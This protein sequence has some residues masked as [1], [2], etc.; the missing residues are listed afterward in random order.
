M[1][2]RMGNED[3]V[4]LMLALIVMIAA[5][6]AVSAIASRTMNQSNH[7]MAYI[8]FDQTLQGI[9]A[10]FALARVELTGQAG[11]NPE[12][13]DGRIGVDTSYDLTASKPWFGS[14]GVTPFHMESMPDVEYFAFSYDWSSDGVDNNGDGTIDEAAEDDYYSVYS[15]ARAPSVTRRAEMTFN[16]GNINIWQN[17]IFAGSGQGPNLINGNVSIHGSVHLLG[18]N[19]ADGDYALDLSGTAEI[20]N[21]YD[22]M[23]AS[24]EARV[25]PLETTVVAGETVETLKAKL[26]VKNGLV[27]ISGSAEIGKPQATGNSSKEQMDGI[28]V[29]D[30]W[31]GNKTDGDGNPS[32]VYSD[33]GWTE[34][35]DLG[36]SVPFPTYPND[37]GRDHLAYYLE[38]DSNPAVGLQQI[39]VGD[40]EIEANKGFYWNATTGT[41]VTNKSPGQGGMPTS[42]NLDF[43]EYFIWFDESANH[44]IINGRIP[45]DGD[46]LFDRGNGNDRTINYTG[47]GTI[48]AYDA[49]SS[50]N[51]GEVEILTDLLTQDLGGNTAQSYPVNNLLGVMAETDMTLGG[52]SQL[53]LMGG[54]YAQEMMTVNKQSNIVGSIVGSSFAMSQVPDIYQVPELANQWSAEMRMIGADPINVLTP[55]S[56]REI[57]IL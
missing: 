51:G 21:N 12:D 25:P 19:L 10:G 11:G 35:Y 43:N 44:M 54:F 33:N 13:K 6:L 36:G 26:R 42:G 32:Q 16:G 37:G 20:T 27:G 57:G 23:P 47:K 55:L 56:W 40:L 52:N 7:A 8:E 18:D 1:H 41:K 31:G 24:L 48:L 15:Y 49:D 22:G 45:V 5:A 53:S 34:A 9:E 30:G 17:A 28:Y 3:G 2:K 29:T 4:A 39:H 38:L 46:V 14:T 50:G